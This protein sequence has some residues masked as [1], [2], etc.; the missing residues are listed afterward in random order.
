[1]LGD[2]DVEVNQLSW[3]VFKSCDMNHDIHIWLGPLE[4][5]KTESE[6]MHFNSALNSEVMFLKFRKSLCIECMRC[7]QHV[8]RIESLNESTSPNGIGLNM[9]T[10]FTTPS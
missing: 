6:I 9:K 7:L 10:P 4:L 1:M 8:F 2:V 3:H 5:V